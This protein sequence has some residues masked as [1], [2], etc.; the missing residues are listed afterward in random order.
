MLNFRNTNILFGVLTAGMIAYNINQHVAWYLYLAVFL[1]YSMILF[2][3]SSTVGANFYMKLMNSGANTSRQIAI[4]FD[5]GPADNYTSQVLDILSRER[6]PSAFFCIGKN[7]AGR[8]AILK[9]IISEDH[10]IGNHS[11]SHHFWFD[12]YGAEKMQAD[13]Q[14]MN[15]A[16]KQVSGL[17]PALF[18]PPYGV[19]NPNLVKAVKRQGLTP[20]GW[21]VRSLDTMIKDPEKLLERMMS[22]VKPGAIVL[23]HDTS[24]ATFLMLPAFIERVRGLG[25]EFVRLD[26]MLNIPAYA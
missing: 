3:G 25:F 4:S 18:R 12:M 7:I 24:E 21:N 8:E 9:R 23:F 20:V 19:T 2:Y 22:S 6:V 13:L 5:D 11:Y 1:V 17:E 26:K 10:I 14:Q 15:A 16:V